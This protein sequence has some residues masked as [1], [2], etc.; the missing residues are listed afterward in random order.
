MKRNV[1]FWK[2]CGKLLKG[3]L[4]VVC[5]LLL[6][7]IVLFLMPMSCDEGYSPPYSLYKADC[8]L[9]TNPI[10]AMRVLKTEGK[11]FEE[12]PEREKMYYQLLYATATELIGKPLKSDSAMLRVADYFERNGCADELSRTY[13]IIGRINDRNKDYLK[14]LK[15]YYR[16][17]DKASELKN[18]DLLEAANDQIE[19]ILFSKSLPSDS[20]SSYKKTYAERMKKLY[21]ERDELRSEEQLQTFGI[22]IMVVVAIILIALVIL[23]RIKKRRRLTS[24]SVKE[25]APTAVNHAVNV[26]VMIYQDSYPICSKIRKNASENDFRLQESEWGSLFSEMDSLCSGFT[27]RLRSRLPRITDVELAVCC[28]TKLDVRNVDIAHILCRGESSVSSIRSRLYEKISGVKG[29]S[30]LFDEF[31]RTF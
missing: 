13:F 8:L 16:S 20:L 11:P 23:I 28:L 4:M 19:T 18:Y 26:D 17:V 12:A 5:A 14:A 10:L 3:S 2:D 9:H 27:M 30:R 24:H 15:Y 7:L 1:F 22:V 6:V 31:I 25:V 29:S 21:A